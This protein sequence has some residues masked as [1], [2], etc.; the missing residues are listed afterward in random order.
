MTTEY[1]KSSLQFRTETRHKWIDAAVARLPANSARHSGTRASPIRFDGVGDVFF[2]FPPGFFSAVGGRSCTALC[3]HLIPHRFILYIK[4]DWRHGHWFSSAR[5]R[6]AGQRSSA[7]SQFHPIR[8]RKE[9][10]ARLSLLQLRYAQVSAKI[11]ITFNLNSFSGGGLKFVEFLIEKRQVNFLLIRRIM[12][13]R[14]KYQFC[15]IPW[16]S[17]SLPKRTNWKKLELI[18]SWHKVV[19]SSAHSCS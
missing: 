9:I 2:P 14:I 18:K 6:S 1:R 8:N 10:A 3:A 19:F 17:Y 13:F 12:S 7:P 16:S 11:I 5:S 4:V 15:M